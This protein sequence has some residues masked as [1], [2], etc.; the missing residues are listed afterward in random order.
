MKKL[1]KT[2]ILL[3]LLAFTLGSTVHSQTTIS[4][5]VNQ[6]DN[7]LEINPGEDGNFNGSST[8]F[9]GGEPTAT[10]GF[11][12]YTYNWEP[13]ALLDD[14]EA[15]NPQVISL[16]EATTF[17]LTVTDPGALCEKQAEVFIDFV[18]SINDISE[19][20]LKLYPNPFYDQITLESSDKIQR[21][22]I[23]DFTGKSIHIQKGTTGSQVIDA[24]D[25]APGIYLVTIYF[26][27]GTLQNYR[28]CKGN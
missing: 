19:S 27:N 4:F 13:A 25:Y 17:T 7:P 8:L 22:E 3:A 1:T 16:A 24:Q 18:S 28:I 15:S 6:P 26:S 20:I 14:P 5:V 23:H 12:D 11:G 10:G 2:Q 9:L 21:M